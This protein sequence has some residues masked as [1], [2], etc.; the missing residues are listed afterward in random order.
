M[1]SAVVQVFSYSALIVLASLAGGWL[2]LIARLTHTR[3]QLLMSFV[4]GM[5]LGVGVFHMLPHAYEEIGSLDRAV[6]WMMIGLLAMFFLQRLFHFHQH[7]PVEMEPGAAE[8]AG[9]HH[10][11]DHDHDHDHGHDHHH[12]AVNG[13]PARKASHDIRWLGVAS[14]LTL[15]TLMD[16]IALAASVQVEAEHTTG[17]TLLGF[18]TFLAILLHKP[19]DAVAITALMIE[20][21]WSARM[22]HIVNVLF[23][24]VVPL[25]ATLFYLGVRRM[26]ADERVIVGCALAFSAGNFLCISLSDLLPEVQFHSHDRFWLSV[27]LLLGIAAAYAIGYFETS[28]HEHHRAA[29]RPG[30]SA[31][32]RQDRGRF[33]KEVAVAQSL[34]PSPI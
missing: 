11:H 34:L 31:V 22:R 17:A 1:S 25:G 14:G 21:G 7:G 18:G 29:K 12:D 13:G 26:P 20:S 30:I 6:W 2:L 28:G 3:M 19:L 24:L 5:M 16:G 27:A 32:S 9:S 15:H 4:A 10:H 8:A 23:A 33:R